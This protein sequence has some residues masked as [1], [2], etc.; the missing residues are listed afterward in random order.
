MKGESHMPG[1]GDYG[2]WQ[3]NEGVELLKQCGITEG[4]KVLDFG[5]GIGEYSIP[6]SKAVGDSGL[7][8]AVDKKACY[9]KNIKETCETYQIQGI[10]PIKSNEIKLDI[11][12]VSID[13]VLYFDL[14]HQMGKFPKIRTEENQRILYKITENLREGGLLLLAVFSEMQLIWDEVNGPFAKSGAISGQHVS[15]EEGIRWFQMVESVEACGFKL[16]KRVPGA[17]HFDE[18]WKK[19]EPDMDS[20][21]KNDI[22]VFRKIIE[23]QNA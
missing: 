3:Y 19:G 4:M 8:Y 18:F 1:Y 7:V 12:D 23:M 22:Y 14:Y 2:R 21:E 20:F 6:A 5:C 10:V 11:E 13:C 9:I 16:E 15:M 17:I